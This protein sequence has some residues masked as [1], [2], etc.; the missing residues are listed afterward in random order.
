MECGFFN[1]VASADFLHHTPWRMTW[2]PGIPRTWNHQSSG[3]ATRK[4]SSSL[5][6]SVRPTN[7]CHPWASVY[8]IMRRL[9]SGGDAG[10][11]VLRPIVGMSSPRGHAVG[12]SLARAQVRA[13]AVWRV[14][15]RAIHP[16]RPSRGAPLRCSLAPVIENIHLVH[17]GHVSRFERRYSPHDLACGHIPCGIVVKADDEHPG[18]GPVGRLDDL[19]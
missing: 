19:V 1:Y 16:L 9:A 4:V 11:G 14:R 12:A 8:L 17:H 3:R 5:S 2:L 10:A 13:G 15:R 18:V 6:M 7:T